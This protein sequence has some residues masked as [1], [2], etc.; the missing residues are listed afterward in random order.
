MEHP[1]KDL[2]KKGIHNISIKSACRTNEFSLG[3]GRKLEMLTYRDKKF[4]VL[5]LEGTDGSL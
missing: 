2:K 4:K 3:L 5:L 1:P